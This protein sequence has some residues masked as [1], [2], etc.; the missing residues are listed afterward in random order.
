VP[1]S[2]GI[3]CAIGLLAA[4]VRRDF[5]TTYLRQTTEVTASDVL[6]QL[7]A[8]RRE[9]LAW[10]TEEG[11]G[12]TQM[13]LCCLADMRYVG[14]NYEITVPVDPEELNA[15][16]LRLILGRFYA[17]HEKLYGHATERELTQFVALRVSAQGKV[18]KPSFREDGAVAAT[19]MVDTRDVYFTGQAVAITTRIIARDSLHR[20]EVV[21]GPAIIEQYDST[22]VIPPGWRASVDDFRNLILEAEGE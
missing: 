11:V 8:L 22:T 7:E 19:E 6:R 1:Y 2:P 13:E 14:Q 9:A 3:L 16:G 5:S 21:S 15:D 18:P 10:L 12:Q 4:D 17:E 20:G